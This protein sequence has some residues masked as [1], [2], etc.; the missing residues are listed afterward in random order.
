[1]SDISS[2]ICRSTMK[3]RGT[4]PA[5]LLPAKLD[6]NLFGNRQRIIHILAL[7]HQIG[8]LDPT[9]TPSDRAVQLFGLCP[10]ADQVKVALEPCKQGVDFDGDRRPANFA[11]SPKSSMKI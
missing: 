11:P 3:L 6:V 1:M 7:A 8:G 5:C 4:E 9:S 2:Q 10:A